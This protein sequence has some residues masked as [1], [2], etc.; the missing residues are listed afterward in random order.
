[1]GEEDKSE[2]KDA[3]AENPNYRRDTETG[4]LFY[5]DP[6]S[7]IEYI[8]DTSKNSWKKVT[9]SVKSDESDEKEIDY[10]FDGQTYIH[11]DSNGTKFKWS[12]D[13]N[14]WVKYVESESEESEEDE[15]T[16]DAQRKARMFRKR[17]AA[18]GWDNAQANYFKDPDSGVQLY[19][20]PQDGMTYEWDADKKAW[21]PRINEDF[22]AQYQ[23]NY[24]FTKDGVAEPTKVS[25][26]LF[27]LTS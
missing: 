9:P 18:P 19:K 20:D 14:E 26:L 21:F 11:T 12:Q 7:Q 25:F 4:E 6:A 22:V 5:K 10:E 13:K 2:V 15:N 16:T 17:K 23:M 27:Y 3:N 1:M 8:W 24:G